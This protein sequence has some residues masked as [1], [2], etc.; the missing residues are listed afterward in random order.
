MTSGRAGILAEHPALHHRLSDAA[1][2]F[3]RMTDLTV[4]LGDQLASVDAHELP[5]LPRCQSLEVQGG[6][7]AL[8]PYFRGETPAD[9]PHFLNRRV[10]DM[11]P[12]ARAAYAPDQARLPGEAAAWRAHSASLASV[13]VGAMPMDT[14]MPISRRRHSRTC[15]PQAV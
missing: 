11:I 12:A 8:G 13:L 5:C 3:Q 10:P 1:E 9:A 7:H 15:L 4:Q 14:G 2:P 6:M